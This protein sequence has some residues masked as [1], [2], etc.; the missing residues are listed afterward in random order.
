MI[1]PVFARPFVRVPAQLLTHPLV[2][3]LVYSLI[4]SVWHAPTLYDLALRN[5]TVHVLEHIMF[6]G[7]AV[8]YFSALVAMGIRPKQFVHRG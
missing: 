1:D 6:F 2:C 5:K 3:A 7:A 4:V 8:L